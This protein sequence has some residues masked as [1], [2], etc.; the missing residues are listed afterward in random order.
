MGEKRPFTSLDNE[1]T[2]GTS[3]TARYGAGPSAKKRKPNGNSKHKA[4]E[5]SIQ[6][7]KKRARNIE[8]LL[9]KNENLPADVRK[10]L[11]RELAAHSATVEDREFR[12]HRSAMITRYH[13]ARF[14]GEPD[15]IAS[16]VLGASAC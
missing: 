4:K 15:K 14:F 2:G 10:D 16:I 13:K 12:K 6:H 1:A 3:L 9:Q 5:G 7:T 8:R 11:E